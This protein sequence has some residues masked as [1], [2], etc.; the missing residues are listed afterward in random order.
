MARMKKIAISIPG[1]LVR[2]VE[3]LRRQTGETRSGFISAAIALALRE[4]ERGKLVARYLEGY[5]RQPESKAEIAA[6]AA[7]SRILA[8]EPWE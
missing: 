1:D 4:R 2:Q 6:A 8:G 3:I 7:G 5:R